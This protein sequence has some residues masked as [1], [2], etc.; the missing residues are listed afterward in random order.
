MLRS[1][2]R[3]YGEFF[4]KKGLGLELAIAM[5]IGQQLTDI[6]RSIDTAHSPKHRSG[7]RC[8]LFRGIVRQHYGYLGR[9]RPK[10]H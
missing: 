6:T 10:P 2:L 3:E 9:E 1:V 8:A 5:V 7:R 4:L